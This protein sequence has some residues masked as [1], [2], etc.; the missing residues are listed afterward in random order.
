MS[1]NALALDQE[2]HN[3]SSSNEQQR[4]EK[5]KPPRSIQGVR[6]FLVCLAIFSC[7]LLYGL[8]NTI[9]ANIQPP[10]IASFGGVNKLGWLGIGFPLGSIA[11]IL[12]IGKAY[13]IFDVKWLYVGSLTM[14]AAGSA[15][16]GAAPSMNALIVGRVWAGA[17][18]AGMYLGNLNLIQTL[19]TPRERS[20]YMSAIVLVY[21][22]GA[23]LGPVIG[24]SLADSSKSGWRWAFYLNLFIFAAMG[25]IYIFLLPSI[26]PRPGVSVWTKVRTLD[27]VG[28]VLSSAI[29]TTFAMIF[30]FGGSIWPWDD[31]RTIALY[32][33][34]AAITIAFAVT[35]YFAW[36]TTKE[37]RL[38]PGHFLYSRT[39]LLLF[40]CSA[41]L[42]G[43]LF[44]CIYYIP[45]YFQFVR[46]DNGVQAA[47]RLL[48]FICF[49]VFSVVLNGVFMIRLGYYMPWFLASGI[50]TTIG[51]ALLYTSTAEMPVANV[52]GYTILVGL[53]MSAYQAAYSVV[54]T[55]VKP[56]E[57]A[58]VIQFI[59]VAQQGSILIALTICSTVFQNVA[60]DRLVAIL[61]PAGYSTT[62]VRAAI[63][64]A[65]STVL[66]SAP[67]DVRQAALDVLV[68][69]IDY[70][71]SLV[72]VSGG[73]M[74]ICSV[75]MKR[76]KIVMD[77][78]A[79]G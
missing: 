8:D 48:P 36:F 34:C 68:Q 69:A 79:G 70:A 24:G 65:R 40:I 2:M 56:D 39:L 54:P 76:E 27:W 45:L 43:A 33:V 7:N 21:G 61:V 12:P 51:G 1:D 73:L 67:A 41:C 57:I 20:V 18:G 28:A 64:G 32:V 38:F 47:V 26:Q 53:G 19:T 42:G 58:E 49:Y 16:C 23:I 13:A 31:G 10:I 9:V 46:N 6:W 74:I 14:F 52:Y 78:V 60:F 5:S 71:Y 63:A 22:A 30:T 4:D 62:D 25:P 75:L 15:L 3:S 55:K 29:Y 17:G 77:F 50:F 72:I 11:I 35:Q 44:A 37:N 66:Q 59:N